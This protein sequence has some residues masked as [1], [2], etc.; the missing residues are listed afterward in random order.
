VIGQ[1]A[2]QTHRIEAEDMGLALLTLE[3]GAYATV[4]CSTSIVPGLPPGMNFY[5]ENGSI[6][7]KG[8]E[9]T[10]W[11]VPDVPM[12][13]YSTDGAVGAGAKDPRNISSIHHKHQIIDVIEAVSKKRKP[14]VQGEDGRDAVRL[15][16]LIY[17]SSAQGG[18]PIRYE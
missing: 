5:G 4:M 17:E 12:P 13:K 18:V 11:A 7:I 6:Q 2:T 3:N 16:E 10:H 14:S 1:V 8:P 9:I 15:I